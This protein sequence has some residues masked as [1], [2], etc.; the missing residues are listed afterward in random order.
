[1]C[2]SIVNT[3]W[4]YDAKDDEWTLAPTMLSRMYNSIGSESMP[5]QPGLTV[6][7]LGMPLTKVDG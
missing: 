2:N 1:M 7:C 5:R 4:C 6:I 3:V